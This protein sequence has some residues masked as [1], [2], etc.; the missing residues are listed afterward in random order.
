MKHGCPGSHTGEI[1]LATPYKKV[2]I[3]TFMFQKKWCM[4]VTLSGKLFSM[5]RYI[6]EKREVM[7][8]VE[9]SSFIRECQIESRH[10]VRHALL[11]NAFINNR[12]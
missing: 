6:E 5:S 11:P 4:T 12:F 10:F 1:I 2:H 7:K 3:L 8:L 9:K